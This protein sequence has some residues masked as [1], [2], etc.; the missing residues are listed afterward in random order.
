[1]ARIHELPPSAGSLALSLRDLGYSL[2]TAIADI[3]DNSITAGATTVEV[4]CDLT[5]PEPALSI[6]DNGTG[7]SDKEL[8][9]AMRHGGKG[10]STP[11]AESDLGRFGLGLKTASFSQCRRLTVVSRKARSIA[12]AEWD[13]DYV[14]KKDKWTVS[15]LDDRDTKAVPH[16]DLLPG[17]GTLVLW[18]KL[19]RLFDDGSGHS[20]EEIVN[21][22]LALLR[23]HLSLV[24]HRFLTGEV[25]PK[26][27]DIKINGHPL[28]PFDPFCTSNKATQKLP[29]EVIKIGGK[30]VTIQPFILPHH[31]RLS[32]REYDFYKTRSDFISNQG[33]YVYRNGRLMAWGDWFRLVP[34][35][36]ATKLG[37]VQI[38]FPSALDEAWTIDIK[39]SRAHPPRIIREHLRQ[40]LP[41]ITGAAV[42][43]HKGRGQKLLQETDSPIWERYAD[44]GQIRYALNQSHPIFCALIAQ[45][46]EAGAQ[47]FGAFLEAIPASLPIDLIYS[48]Y[49]NDPKSL[50][51]KEW[52]EA[53]VLDRL[54]ILKREL[55]VG[56]EYDAEQFLKIVCSTRLFDSQI[57][58]VEAFA[59]GEIG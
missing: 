39:K 28:K 30:K 51:A 4:L 14:I 38:D 43:V 3:V 9:L 42:R 13:L 59:R 35:G 2:E 45:L 48:D 54:R 11:R 17:P 36:E 27:L 25:G 26:K 6:L 57:K 49:S 56:V 33:A 20:R 53:E 5:L 24:F 12:A 10:P 22:K 37:R 47:A 32:A 34:K 1:M 8:L 41:K 19:D 55:F 18:R 23:D 46:D 21:A 31:S 7:M 16:A 40:I 44:R 52:D 50:V 29:K 15:I 58:L